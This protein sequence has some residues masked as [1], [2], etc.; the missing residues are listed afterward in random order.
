MPYVLPFILGM[1]LALASALFLIRGNWLFLLPLVVGLPVAILFLQYPFIAILLWLLVFPF[2]FQQTVPGSRYVYDLIHRAM[3]PGAFAI[4]LLVELLKKDKK[5]PIRIGAGEWGILLFLIL[6]SANILLMDSDPVGGFIRYYDRLFVPFCI[7]GLVRLTAPGINDLKRLA[8]IAPVVVATQSIIGLLAWFA[9]GK[10]PHV[11]LNRLG[12]RTVGTFGSPGMFTLTL[13]FSSLFL[14]QYA[15]QSRS[16]LIRIFCFSLVGMALFAIFFSFSRGSWLGALLVFLGIFYLYPR[17]M[18]RISVVFAAIIVLV[19]LT[20]FRPY[21]TFAYER[22]T[23]QST[24]DGRILGDYATLHVIGID[25]LFGVGFGNQDLYDEQ[26][27]QRVL[28]LAVNQAHT[29]HNTFLL[30][31]SEMGMV[32]LFFYLIPLGWWFLASRKALS[33]MPKDGFQGRTMLIMLWLFFLAFFAIANFTDLFQS[34]LFAT[35]LWWMTLGLIATLTSPYLAPD[36]IRKRAVSRS[37]VS[38]IGAGR[39]QDESHNI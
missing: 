1:L 27:R 34:G 8:W 3:I 4:A 11:W 28:D 33:R 12:E 5:N 14:I 37:N 21:L 30:I 20:F 9:P 25:P 35:G 38:R 13:I 17:L 23:T 29:S 18:F 2:F 6:S 36:N 16:K 22:L 10:L 7:Y 15:I 32:G 39:I 24:A 19:T 26:F 31:T